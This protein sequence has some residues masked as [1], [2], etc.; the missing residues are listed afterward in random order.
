MSKTIK[1][2][3]VLD[4]TAAT[5]QTLE[6]VSHLKNINVLLYSKATSSLLAGISQ[7][8][9]NVRAEVPENTV[10]STVNGRY[11]IASLNN[12]KPMF[13]MVNGDV[14]IRPEADEE[15]LKLKVAGMI[16]N[17]KMWCPERL[18]GI[19]QQKTV[20]HNG[21]LISFMN[22]A[23][24]VTETV[25]LNNLYLHTLADN[26][27]IS[28]A[29]KV[30]MLD[31]V[32]ASLLSGKLQ[33]VEFMDRLVIRED[34]LPAVTEKIVHLHKAAIKTIPLN[35]YYVENDLTLDSNLLK[36]VRNKRLHAEG[37]I[38]IDSG[39]SPA[40][41]GESG[42]SLH[43]DAMILC[44]DEL[45]DEVLAITPD[46]AVQVVGC[47]GKLRVV[48][49]EYRLTAAELKYTAET[50]AFIVQG[51]LNISPDVE[52][53]LLMNAAG[54]IVNFGVINGSAE[55]C[56]IVRTKLLINKGVVGEPDSMEEHDGDTP[57]EAGQEDDTVYIKNANYLKL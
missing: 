8:N 44:G 36:R 54:S 56:G 13:I 26:A 34:L 6:G 1:N 3:N 48:E 49:G 47:K 37:V 53:E 31:D 41:L 46:P 2:V 51:V 38:R 25:R 11:E 19:V 30:I 55:Q 5:E 42:I 32:D 21:R 16:V 7:K 52:P 17:G 28:F 50:Q 35:T 39:V 45:T 24:L 33:A 9:I 40:A 20:N 18:S 27:R 43:S 15:A 10:L 23:E 12:E 22:D 57:P 4:I 14:V 29:G